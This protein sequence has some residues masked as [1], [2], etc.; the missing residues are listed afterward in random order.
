[1]DRNYWIL[2]ATEREDGERMSRVNGSMAEMES[3]VITNDSGLAVAVPSASMSSRV[4]DSSPLVAGLPESRTRGIPSTPLF[5]YA[6]LC[7]PSGFPQLSYTKTIGPVGNVALHHCVHS[8]VNALHSGVTT[9]R[10]LL[11]DT[12]P[13]RPLECNRQEPLPDGT[14]RPLIRTLLP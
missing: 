8:S 3:R 11:S 1:M 9:V 12:K 5:P 10:I 6:L 4:F 13:P 14:S 7:A 2:I